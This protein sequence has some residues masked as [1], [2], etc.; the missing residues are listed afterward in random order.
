MADDDLKQQADLQAVSPFAQG[1]FVSCTLEAAYI[2]MTHNYLSGSWVIASK[3]FR[4]L[5]G[6]NLKE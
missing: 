3:Q 1:L 5:K 6:E 2:R 4:L